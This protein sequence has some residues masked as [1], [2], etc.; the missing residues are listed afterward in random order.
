MKDRRVPLWEEDLK[1]LGLSLKTSKEKLNSEI[2]KKLGL[3]K[4]EVLT[5][6][7]RAMKNLGLREDTSIK[8]VWE[9]FSKR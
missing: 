6:K 3:P 1:Q 2:R 7:Q 9:I 8:K 5:P 4:L